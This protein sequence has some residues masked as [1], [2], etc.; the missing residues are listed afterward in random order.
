MRMENGE[1]GSQIRAARC[2]CY[3]RTRHL[4]GFVHS[5]Q[6][7]VVSGEKGAAAIAAANSENGRIRL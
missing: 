7:F 2:F 4:R 6:G 3:G 5:T 1:P